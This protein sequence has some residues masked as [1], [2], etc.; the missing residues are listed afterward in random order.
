MWILMWVIQVEGRRRVAGCDPRGVGFV[1]IP[2]A[3]AF[4]IDRQL[5]PLFC[6]E[7]GTAEA[8]PGVVDQGPW[9]A[10][11]LALESC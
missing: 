2:G 5:K 7:E 3:V 4:P 1:S 9:Q 6:G 8:G 10:A 11:C